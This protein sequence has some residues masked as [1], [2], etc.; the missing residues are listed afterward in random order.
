MEKSHTSHQKM[1]QYIQMCVSILC[2]STHVLP[3]T[4][5]LIPEDAIILIEITL[6]LTFLRIALR[7]HPLVIW[8]LH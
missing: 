6:W 4:L 3:F 2:S 5:S 7:P 1:T 8:E